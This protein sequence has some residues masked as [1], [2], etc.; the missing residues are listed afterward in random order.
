MSHPRRKAPLTPACA[1]ITPAMPEPTVAELLIQI[2]G[3]RTH[4]HHLQEQLGRCMA[5]ISTMGAPLKPAPVRR[6]R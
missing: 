2:H 5:A 6:K 4:I 1:P 3:L